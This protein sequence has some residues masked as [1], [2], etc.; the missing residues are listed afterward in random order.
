MQKKVPVHQLTE[1]AV[2]LA[3]AMVLSII[4]VYQMPY[5]GSI[6]LCSMV[7]ILY[8]SFRY[9]AKWSLFTAFVYGALQMLLDFYPP[10]AQ[11]FVAFAGVVALDYAL[12]FGCLGLAGSVGRF[13]KG[14][15]GILFGATV[16]VFLRFLCHFASGI[17]IWDVFAPEGQSVV[18]YSFLYNGSY[19]LGEWAVTAIGLVAL[20][21]ILRGYRKAL[22]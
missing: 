19:M 16:V 6:T 5:G 7:P 3:L 20:E 21:R 10:P 8:L 18:L 12:A 2:M 15:P 1:S 14:I 11:T 17:I 22:L 4:K 9:D 13:M